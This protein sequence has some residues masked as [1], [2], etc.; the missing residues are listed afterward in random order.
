[1]VYAARWRRVRVA[2]P[3]L[4]LT[5]ILMRLVWMQL[6]S[7]PVVQD[8]R[9]LI[10]IERLVK[11]GAAGCVYER[12]QPGESTGALAGGEARERAVRLWLTSPGHALATRAACRY[13]ALADRYAIKLNQWLFAGTVLLATLMTRF[14]TS[15]WT[16]SLIVAGML[17]SRGG[18]LAELGRVSAD[19]LL[20]FSFTLWMTCIA[21]YLRTGA[22]VAFVG[23]ALAVAVGALFDRALAPLALAMPIVLGVGYAYRRQ[24]ARPVIQRLR[25][26]NRQLRVFQRQS[27]ALPDVELESFFGRLSTGVRWLLGMEFPPREAT[28]FMPSFA[29][30]GL[31]RT[32]AVPFLLWAY[33]KRRWLQLTS[34][35]LAAFAVIVAAIVVGYAW[36]L[37]AGGGIAEV[38][39]GM[40]PSLAKV[41]GHF[42][43]LWALL[44]LE[45]MDLHLALS[46][47]VML[48]CALQSPAA[49]L[50]GFLEATWIALAGCLLVGAFACGLDLLD[51]QLVE[52]LPFEGRRML[53]TLAFGPRPFMLWLEPVVLSLGAAGVYNLMKVFDTRV[54][55]KS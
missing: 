10:A 45:R 35:W 42:M 50:A 43:H 1:M 26:V 34:A 48:T 7:Y 2:I 24:L 21:H 22:P 31:F 55:E 32:L 20:G 41:P 52:Q 17:M 46:F 37:D 36:M 33:H 54:A 19:W 9:T 4:L 38:L 6:R 47:F 11:D 40:R 28:G 30:G 39:A 27:N 49:G 44:A 12:S 51:A 53:W 29:R 16:V 13:G 3:L 5:M 8:P 14:L 15:S 18:L 25:E 23:A